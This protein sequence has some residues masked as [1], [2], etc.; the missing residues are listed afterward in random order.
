MKLKGKKLFRIDMRSTLISFALVPMLVTTLILSIVLVNTSS[1]ELKSS[2]SNS[3]VSLIKE[4]GAGFDYSTTQNERM[5]QA[6][7]SAPVVREVLEK[8]GDA[9]LTAKAQAYTESQTAPRWRSGTRR[10]TARSSQFTAMCPTAT[11][12]PCGTWSP[13]STL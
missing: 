4:T 9:A 11:R 2:T 3:L 12:S 10:A 6:F 7:A 1:S 13:G 8:P 5:L